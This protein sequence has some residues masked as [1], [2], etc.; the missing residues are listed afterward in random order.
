MGV[1]HW[2][3]QDLRVLDNPALHYAAELGDVV[4]VYIYEAGQDHHH[5]PGAASRV[6]LH[7]ALHSLDQTLN[8]SLNVYTG[9]PLAILDELC[10][11][12]DVT[13]VCWNA[14]YEPWQRE[15]DE[16]IA[17][18]LRQ[19]HIRVHIFNGALLWDPE[20]IKKADGTPYKVFTPFYTKGCL[21]APPPEKPLPSVEGRIRCVSDSQRH[22]VDSLGFLPS[23]PWDKTMMA[24]W[25][26]GEAGALELWDA[27]L[28]KGIVQYKA[29]RNIPSKLHV[30]RL[31]PYLHFGQISVRYLW[32]MFQQ[33]PQNEDIACFCSELGWREFSNHL[34]VHNPTL[35]TQ[36]LYSKF[37]GFPWVNNPTYLRAWQTGQTGIPMVDA[38]MRELWQTGYMHNRPRMIVGSF[39]VKNLLIDWR[40]GERWFWDCLVDAD[41]A[42]NSASWQWIAGCGADAAPYFRVF[43]PVTQ[44][45]KFDPDGEYIKRFVPELRALPPKYLFSPWEAPASVLAACNISLGV[46]YPR[47]IVDVKASRQQALDAYFSLK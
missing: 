29:G 9:D 42:N 26:L 13:D 14:C 1:I 40:H 21:Q 41:L 30:S 11:R 39:L 34:L 37:D 7:H 18:A 31:S 45:E 24:E 10:R 20:S 4:P 38:A 44:G 6:W 47:P 46:T 8:Q 25:P 19:R 15:Q 17:T 12:F 16:A 33:Y 35:P 32:H 22:S 3:R 23:I 36:N 28:E 27:F 2:F 43:N 5:T